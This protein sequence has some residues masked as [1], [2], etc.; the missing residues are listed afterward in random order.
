MAEALKKEWRNEE[1]WKKWG[2]GK[3]KKNEKWIK[4]KMK[5]KGHSESGEWGRKRKNEKGEHIFF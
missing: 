1:K 2:N 5:K 3:K 4:K